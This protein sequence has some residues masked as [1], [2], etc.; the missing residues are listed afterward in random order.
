M[1]GAPNKLGLD[2]FLDPVGHFGALQ[3]VSERPRRRATRLVFS[4]FFFGK[5]GGSIDEKM[6]QVYIF[7]QSICLM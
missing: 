6:V 5:V 3:A 7:F 1:I 4:R 2:P